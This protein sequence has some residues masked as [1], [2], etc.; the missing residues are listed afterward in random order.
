MTAAQSQRQD[1]EAEG[2]PATIRADKIGPRPAKSAAPPIQMDAGMD[3]VAL[4]RLPVLL[5]LVVDGEGAA[6][7]EHS[8]GELGQVVVV[9]IYCCAAA[10]F[11]GAPSGYVVGIETCNIV[12]GASISA[13]C[14]SAG[15]SNAA[16]PARTCERVTRM[17]RDDRP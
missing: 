10:G 14:S 4:R 11:E 2:S 16:R 1:G 9:E 15:Q 12:P 8:V 5:P 6:I 17:L 7:V 3:E 13:D